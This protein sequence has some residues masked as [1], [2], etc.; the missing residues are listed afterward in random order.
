[1]ILLLDL[2]DTL[3]SNEMDAFQQPYLKGLG[4]HLSKLVKPDLM[5]HELL[6]ATRAMVSNQRIDQ[7]L[8]EVFDSHFYPALGLSKEALLPSIDEFYQV[9]YPTLKSLIAPRPKAIRVV[10]AAMAHG[11]RLVV[12][13]NPLFPKTAI[14][15]RL[16]WGKLSPDQ[17][18]FEIITS[19]ET[20]HFSKPNPAYYSEIMAQLGWPNEPVMMVGNDLENDIKPAAQAGMATYWVADR[21]QPGISTKSNNNLS[22]SLDD[23]LNWINHQG[24]DSLPLNFA[25]QQAVFHNLRATPAALFSMVKPFSTE[26]WGFH[27][28]P[29]EWCLTEVICHLRDVECEVNT[30]RLEKFKAEENPFLPGIATDPWAVERGYAS[31][32]GVKAL[33]DFSTCR[34][35]TISILDSL[36]L[37]DWSRTVRHA[38]FGPTPLS[39]LLSFIATHDRSHLQQTYQLTRQAR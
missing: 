6:S 20:S 12:A 21:N 24:P 36:P 8:E 13:T 16:T 4:K 38:I 31:Q 37:S 11:Y 26:Q 15:Q 30:P 28:A 19:Y 5:V 33:A 17:Y 22:G 10:E 2:D 27:P 32:D 23:L 39:E 34:G 3:I 35:K 1:M 14:T 7:T 18:P 29:G 25:T 9:V